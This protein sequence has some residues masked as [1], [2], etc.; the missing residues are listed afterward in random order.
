MQGTYLPED[1]VVSD[2]VDAECV[3]H[4]SEEYCHRKQRQTYLSAGYH[5]DISRSVTSLD[6]EPVV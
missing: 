2:I 6:L 3:L 4:R 1:V 5:W